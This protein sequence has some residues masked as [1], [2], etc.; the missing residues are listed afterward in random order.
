MVKH[1]LV[2]ILACILLSAAVVM[3]GCMDTGKQPGKQPAT[4]PTAGTPPATPAVLQGMGVYRADIMNSGETITAGLGDTVRVTLEENPSTGYTWNATTTPGLD[5]LADR[6]EPS[7]VIG[8][9]AGAGGTRIWDL[10]AIQPGPQVFTA[11]YSRS[12]ESP[13]G[14]ETNFS[15]H[16]QVG[17]VSGIVYTERDNENAVQMKMGDAFILF[18]H[19]N[20]ATGYAWNMSMSSGLTVT[21]DR[22]FPEQRNGPAGAGG[23]HEWDVKVTGSGNQ[24]IYGLDKRPDETTTGNE[25]TFML[26]ISVR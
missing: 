9:I 6:F 20:P 3:T 22:F 24:T 23:M 13:A 16:V 17:G 19:E 5:I 10:K 18:L 21:A 26:T 7:H 2:R 25:D 4:T 14:D 12:D 8:P 15:I 11:I 1:S